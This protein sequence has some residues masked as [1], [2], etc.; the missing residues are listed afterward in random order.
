M[1]CCVANSQGDHPIVYDWESMYRQLEDFHRAWGTCL[2]P[3]FLFDDP[4][5]GR[6]VNHLRRI[7]RTKGIKTWQRRQLEAL[8]FEFE[9]SQWDS[10]WHHLFHELR[11][12]KALH[13]SCG[14]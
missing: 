3:R 6:W 7:H 11:R 5:L 13:G 10:Q 4:K 9:V 1:C 14:E 12:Y 2:V 8:N